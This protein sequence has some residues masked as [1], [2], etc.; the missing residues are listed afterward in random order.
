MTSTAE[1]PSNGPIV[2][3]RADSDSTLDDMFAVVTPGQHIPLQKPMKM[4]NLPASFFK[5]PTRSI[6]P[7]TGS[8]HSREN[9]V[10]NSLSDPFSPGG[11]SI[12]SPQPASNAAAPG[13]CHSR[14]HSSPATLQQTLAVAQQQGMP[15]H[16]RQPSYDVSA[17]DDLGPLPPGWE[18][19]KT[20]NGQLYFMDHINKKTQWEDPRKT[21]QQPPPMSPA[22]QLNQS[23]PS[24]SPQPPPVGAP[25]PQI[26]TQRRAGSFNNLGPLPEGYEESVT[27]D[28]EVYFI[29][30]LTRQTT[31]FDPRVPMHNQRVPVNTKT[32][33]GISEVQRRQQDA[34]LQRL[35][36]ERTRLKEKQQELMKRDR[37][38]SQNQE[39]QA[40]MN[41][42]QEMLMRQSLG[43]NPVV[44]SGMDPFLSNASQQTGNTANSQSDLHNR[45]ESADSGVGMGSNFNLGSIPEDLPVDMDSAMDVGSD[46]DTTLTE[47]N[48]N[49]TNAPT[50]M[51]DNNA[52]NG[53]NGSS[54]SGGGAMDTTSSGSG[55]RGDQ[56]IPS[57][58][59]E[60]SDVL[61]VLNQD[62]MILQD[63]LRTNQGGGLTWL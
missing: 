32:F 42:A 62:D 37:C 46:L 23:S 24:M 55:S 36:M 39:V 41:H 16:L 14:A 10:D 7:A 31:W 50:N 30:H 44:T 1:E 28:G 4:R 27:P 60:L 34:R 8:T 18:M 22:F 53:T 40:A 63:V 51:S 38:Q 5:P 9:S 6:S 12:G 48:G 20:A 56:L 3:V 19:A 58:P 17:P 29:N 54:G 11:Q 52:T 49:G 13:P 45:Q 43:E 61:P 2:H 26:S 15:S 35:Q 33:A 21:M 25:K 47:A 57:I 59:A